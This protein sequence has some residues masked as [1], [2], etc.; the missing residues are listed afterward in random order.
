VT[1]ATLDR[2]RVRQGAR[3]VPT[4]LLV[5]SAL[6][7]AAALLHVVA[8]AEHLAEYAPFA[9]CFAVV[10]VAQIAIAARLYRRPPSPAALRAAAASGLALIAVWALSRTIGLPVGPER[11]T[12]EPIGALDVVASADEALLAVLVALRLAGLARIRAGRAAAAVASVAGIVLVAV[13]ALAF[14]LA[15]AH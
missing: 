12:P 1:A 6:A 3:A 5:A 11:W 13:S 9:A 8:A 15:G 7:G 2:T 4:D 10:G 14:A